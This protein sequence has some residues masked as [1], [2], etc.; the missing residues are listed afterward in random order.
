MFSIYLG[1]NR[2]RGQI[3]PTGEK[4]NNTVYNSTVAGVIT[5]IQQTSKK[6]AHSI[7]VK[8]TSGNSVVQNTP[9]GPD[10]IVSLGQTI[11]VDQPITNNPNVG[12]FGQTETEIVLQA[13]SRIQGLI[14]FFG[15]TFF[16]TDGSFADSSRIAMHL[17]GMHISCMGLNE[18]PG[19][20][21]SSG[22]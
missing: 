3:Y 19:T 11:D 17:K 18:L 15:F 12:G 1:G 6:G 20:L 8:D 13:P 16:I 7:T 4:S 22:N 5:D 21:Y 14:V 9:A 2:G 10:L